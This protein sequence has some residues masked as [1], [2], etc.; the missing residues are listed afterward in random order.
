VVAGASD[1][2]GAAFAARLAARGLNVVL[3]ARR[4]PLLDELAGGLRAA[5]G[6][7]VRVVVADLATPAG[8]EAAGGTGE[9][10]G[11]L[12]VN[13]ALSPISP[14]AD[15]T[16][17]DLDAMLAVNCRAAARLTHALG[18]PMLAR[19]RGG[20]ILLSSLAGDQGAALVAHYAATKAYLRVLAVGLWA[21][22]SPRGVDV[23]AC[24]P[25]LVQTPTFA[26]TRPARPG[27]LVPAPMPADDVARAALAALGSRPVVIPGGRNRFAAAAARLLPRA[28]VVALASRQTRAMYPAA[29]YPTGSHRPAR[30]DEPGG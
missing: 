13:A 17:A 4:R 15:L 2:I 25:G 8:I 16:V 27:R 10:I 24:C 20:V 26:R 9:E 29:M 22:W 21:G 5:H 6:V 23:L 12:V 19:G 14:F 28:A 11:L 3:V 18:R 30:V 1:G 7:E